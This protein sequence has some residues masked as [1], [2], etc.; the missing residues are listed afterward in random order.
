MS[1]QLRDVM[2]SDPLVLSR[3]ASVLDAASAM[4]DGD[5]GP[6]L[7]VDDDQRLCGLLTDRD[8]VVRAIV[9]R[10]RLGSTPLADVCTVD[11]AT[12]SPVDTVAD[13]M[14]LM[15]EHAVRRVPV[16]EGGRPVGIVSLADLALHADPEVARRI[17]GTLAGISAAPSDDPPTEVR[18]KVS[19][20]LERDQAGRPAQPA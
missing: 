10:R 4:A 1:Q 2:T 7:V 17:P 19:A 3:T 8:I 20:A 16:V 12:L 9:P 15:D 11:L 14:Q 5:I 6:V 18:P 13:A